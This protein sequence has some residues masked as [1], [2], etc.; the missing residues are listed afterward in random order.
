MAG[1]SFLRARSP[2]TPKITTAQ[3]PA[4][5]GMRLSRLS[6]NG[7]R[8]AVVS[9]LA[10]LIVVLG[11]PRRRSSRGGVELA[12][13]CVEQFLPRLLELVHTLVLEHLEHIDQVDA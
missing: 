11:S 13:C 12:L 8:Q 6:R 3:G 1:I 5:R 2:V 10:G 4:M 9:A 7:L